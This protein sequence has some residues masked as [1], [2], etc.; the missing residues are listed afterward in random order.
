MVF[1]IDIPVLYV[2]KIRNDVAQ[3]KTQQFV[4]MCMEVMD[5]GKEHVLLWWNSIHMN[6]LIPGRI[7]AATYVIG[8]LLNT[9]RLCEF[10]TTQYHAP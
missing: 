6:P 7:Q 1:Y 5:D 9:R 3:Y 8:S 10:S 4:V 2:L